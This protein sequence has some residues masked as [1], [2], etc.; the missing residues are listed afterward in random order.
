MRFDYVAPAWQI[1]RRSRL[2]DA[3]RVCVCHSLRGR[4]LNALHRSA[5]RAIAERPQDL[6]NFLRR[7]G[8]DLFR[9]TRHRIECPPCIIIGEVLPAEMGK[10]V[11]DAHQL[12]CPGAV[13]D[14]QLARKNVAPV[15]VKEAQRRRHIER[16]HERPPVPRERQIA[17]LVVIEDVQ[18]TVLPPMCSVGL[19]QLLADIVR[20]CKEQNT[21]P[22]SH[23]FVIAAHPT[24]LL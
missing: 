19:L 8:I 9:E 23:L 11:A 16:I 21:L 12:L 17:F 20:E 1:T 24:F 18:N 22:L 5:R 15:Q 14:G 7:L 3:T 2:Q 10:L 6:A 13:V 4:R